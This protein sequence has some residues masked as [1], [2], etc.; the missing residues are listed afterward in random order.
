MRGHTQLE[1]SLRTLIRE[2]EA[3]FKCVDTKVAAVVWCNDAGAG[4]GKTAEHW[5]LLTLYLFL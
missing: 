3:V 4:A 1:R 2:K 5:D